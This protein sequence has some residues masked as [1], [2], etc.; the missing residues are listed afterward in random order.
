LGNA[1]S[2]ALDP[3]L[4][5]VGTPDG[6]TGLGEGPGLDL[7]D[8]AYRSTSDDGHLPCNDKSTIIVSLA[9]S[10]TKLNPMT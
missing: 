6:R 7:T 2:H 1:V 5:D 9:S 3:D 8:A 10:V 4:V